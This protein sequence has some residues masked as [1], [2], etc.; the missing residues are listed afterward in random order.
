MATLVGTAAAVILSGG[1]DSSL[2][3]VS[4]AVCSE[5]FST[6]SL[7]TSFAMVFTAALSGGFDASLGASFDA[8]G[9]ASTSFRCPLCLPPSAFCSF[10]RIR[11]SLCRT[12]G[13]SHTLGFS[14]GPTASLGLVEGSCVVIPLSARLLAGGSLSVNRPVESTE[15]ENG[16]R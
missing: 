8:L 12:R 9:T 2:L 11:M 7:V 1:F 15:R 6:P 14:L 16:E 5:D 10:P 3:E 4:V 13:L